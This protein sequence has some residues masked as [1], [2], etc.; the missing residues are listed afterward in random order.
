MIS[1]NGALH[2]PLAPSGD[3]G[4]DPVTGRFQPGNP[5]GR[6]NPF[7]KRVAA[8]RSALLD[9]VTP[10]DIAAAVRALIDRAKAGDV[11]AIREL[12]DRC[13]GKPQETDLFERIEAL[14]ASLQPHLRR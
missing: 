8:L 14:E 11:A 7:A 3:G 4:H 5:G 6:G 13:I 10:E 2:T 1:T 12:L 9:A